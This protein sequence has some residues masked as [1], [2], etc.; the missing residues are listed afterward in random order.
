MDHR[1]E[2]LMK[3]NDCSQSEAFK[4][5]LDELEK[6]RIPM[7]GNTVDSQ[8]SPLKRTIAGGRVNI[9]DD[10]ERPSI[11]QSLYKNLVEK[12]SPSRMATST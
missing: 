4:L 5:Y 3:E 7:D 9:S 12:I 10:S 2:E 1:I 6:N 8:T 11:L